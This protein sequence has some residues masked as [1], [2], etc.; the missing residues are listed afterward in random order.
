MKK[1]LH[2]K[3]FTQN[4]VCTRTDN[5][6]SEPKLIKQH[7]LFTKETKPTYSMWITQLQLKIAQNWCMK[8]FYCSRG[9]EKISS[10]SLHQVPWTDP[11]VIQASQVNSFGVSLNWIAPSFISHL[12]SIILAPLWQWSPQATFAYHSISRNGMFRLL[13]SATQPVWKYHDKTWNTG[14]SQNDLTTL[15]GSFVLNNT[16]S[17]I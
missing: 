10:V 9:S 15:L 5:Y 16:R 8:S 12:Q 3:S 7:C 6:N 2:N 17:A 14:P 11:T 1:S 4:T 13:H